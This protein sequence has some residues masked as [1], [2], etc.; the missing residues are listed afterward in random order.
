MTER[1]SKKN[2]ESEAKVDHHNSAHAHKWQNVSQ[3]VV[4]HR[5]ERPKP[6]ERAKVLKRLHE[7]RRLSSVTALLRQ[8]ESCPSPHFEENNQAVNG[9]RYCRK[10]CVPI[11][12]EDMNQEKQTCFNPT[13]KEPRQRKK[14]QVCAFFCFSLPDIRSRSYDERED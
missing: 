2:E 6:S 1:P 4:G 10:Q 14:V 11:F 9:D 13:E 5:H 8:H 7:K 12:D 3:D